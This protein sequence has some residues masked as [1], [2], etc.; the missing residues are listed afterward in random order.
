MK[1]ICTALL[2][3]FLLTFAQS[4]YPQSGAS[5][6]LPLFG[7]PNAGNKTMIVYLTGD[8]GMNAFSKG[9][10][11]DLGSRG[12]AVVALDTR[13]YFW[14]QKSPAVFG[15]AAEQFI[16]QYLKAWKKTSF[17]LIG[18][19]FGADVGAFVPPQLSAEVAGKLE[20][21]VLLSPGFST[22]FVTKLTNMLG[23]SGSDSDPYKVYPQLLRSPAPVL[24]VFG[25][26]EDSDFFGAIKAGGKIE[27]MTVPGSHR[28]NDDVKLISK[29]ITASF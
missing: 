29:V 4:A 12:Y 15:K 24:C 19:S 22:G 21:V 13:K 9:V 10:I 14:D 11:A 17:R 2:A 18:Y 7:F 1:I 5:Q 27:K 23:F 20:A 8:G 6:N 16:S 26:D 28:Y 25:K 3:C